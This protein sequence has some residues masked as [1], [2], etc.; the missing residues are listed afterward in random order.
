M[1]KGNWLLIAGCLVA[2]FIGGAVSDWALSPQ[3][4]EE[5]QGAGTA[6]VLTVSGLRVV[7]KDNKLRALLG[8][9]RGEPRLFLYDTA[10]KPR[11][12]LGVIGGLPVLE[13]CDA[14]GERRGHSQG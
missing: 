9:K 13:L 2:A 12:G 11:A 6:P 7:D 5:K 10:G 1:G 4:A 3:V 8:V 14:A